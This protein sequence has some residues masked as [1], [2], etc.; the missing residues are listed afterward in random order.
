MIKCQT[1]LKIFLLRVTMFFILVTTIHQTVD[2]T[3]EV[4]AIEDVA[5]AVFDDKVVADL[6]TDSVTVVISS[7]D[8]SKRKAVAILQEYA[9]AK[10]AV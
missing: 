7:S 5:V 6:K 9:S 2:E 10:V 8:L 3:F 1:I 4:V